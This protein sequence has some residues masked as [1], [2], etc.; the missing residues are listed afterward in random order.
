MTIAD[1]KRRERFLGTI[2]WCIATPPRW[3]NR[4]WALDPAGFARCRNGLRGFI[5]RF[6]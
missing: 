1:A 4:L 5:D 3:A 6:E 2:V